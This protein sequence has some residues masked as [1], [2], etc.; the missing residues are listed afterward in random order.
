MEFPIG[1]TYVH[2]YQLRKS[3]TKSK[4]LE[5]SVPKDFVRG[6]ALR[7]GIPF[8][9]FIK[10]CKVTVFYGGGNELLYQFLAADDVLTVE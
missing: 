7:A 10:K 9:E 8:E 1:D 3:G 4:T 6:V 5:V 2:E